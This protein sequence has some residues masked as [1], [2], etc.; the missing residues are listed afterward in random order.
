[1]SVNRVVQHYI[2]VYL[3]KS[4]LPHKEYQNFC[5]KFKN[6]I[7]S[8]QL[9]I[10]TQSQNDITSRDTYEPLYLF[11]E[12]Q[13]L[14]IKCYTQNQ[15]FG[16]M[17]IINNSAGRKLLHQMIVTLSP[18]KQ[19][20]LKSPKDVG[21][22]VKGVL[23]PLKEFIYDL[24][25]RYEL[26]KDNKMRFNSLKQHSMSQCKQIQDIHSFTS[27]MYDSEKEENICENW[28]ELV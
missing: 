4:I 25:T 12:L 26:E 10:T 18:K 28:E 7:E 15:H 21:S 14:L 5:L 6:E 27:N 3:E 23:S 9:L 19:L 13:L 17:Q 1:M 20:L 16:T 8:I 11:S 2:K 22:F 24:K